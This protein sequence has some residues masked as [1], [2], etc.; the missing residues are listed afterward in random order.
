MSIGF[1]FN[2]LQSLY[3]AQL[4]Q[5]AARTSASTTSRAQE[6]SVLTPWDVRTPQRDAEQKLADALARPIT[7]NTN[8]P[9]FDR[10]GVPEDHKKLFG[11]YK[12]LST[13]SAIANEA[14][15]DKTSELRL[16]G[17]NRRFHDGL[18]TILSYVGKTEFDGLSLVAGEKAARVESAV[19]IARPSSAYTGAMAV[20]GAFDSAVAGLTGSETFT[21]HIVKSNVATDVTVDL[22]TISG[23]LTLDAIADAANTALE[24]AGMLT[25]FER[26]ATEKDEDGIARAFGLA[27]EGVGTEKVTLVPGAADPA[28]YL[29]GQSGTGDTAQGRFIKLTDLGA[30]APSVKTTQEFGDGEG[31]ITPA[32]SVTDAQGNVYVVGSTTGDLDGQAVK[33]ESDIFLRKYDSTGKLL[34]SKLL[35]AAESAEGFALASTGDGVVVAGKMAGEL[36]AASV[37]GKGDSVVVKFG[38]DGTEKFARQIA[39]LAEDGEAAITVGGD[40]A[41]YVAGYTKGKLAGVAAHGGGSDG[42]VTKLSATGGLVYNRQIGGAGEE[43]AQS[44]AVAGDGSLIVATIEDGNAVVRKYA[45]GDATS[46]AVWEKN[47]GEISG[48]KLSGIAVSGSDIYIAGSTGKLDFTAGGEASIAQAHSGGQAGFV[49]PLSDAGTSATADRVTYVGTG[50]Y[51]RITGIVVDGTDV[52]VSGVTKGALAG[53][54][55]PLTNSTHGFAAK[56]DASGATVWAKQFAGA[57]G[58]GSA[59]AIAIDTSGSSVLDVL[60]LPRGTLAETKSRLVTSNSSVR[61]GESFIVTVNG[62]ADRRIRIDA[63][64]TLRTLASKIN[65]VLVIEGKAEV[66]R[67][68]GAEVL[69]ITEKD[70]SSI[71]IKRGPDG[72][73]ALEGLGIQ[74][75]RVTADAPVSDDDS[76]TTTEAQPKVFGLNLDSTLSLLSQSK[77]AAAREALSDALS[78]IRN[79]YREITRDPA[80]DALAERQRKLSGPVPAYLREQ[81]A[82]YQ[83]A[84]ARLT[85][86]G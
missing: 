8:D 62:G 69:R 14:A 20:R 57:G 72:Y 6:T 22:S 9:S 21:L 60:G 50:T 27:I 3:T 76:E 59:A 85:G 48:G 37:G 45:S 16:P 28:I 23:P 11:L 52:Y 86:S 84:L 2:L 58:N 24:A 82:G 1:D 43:R 17:L 64:D 63:G 79:A 15:S 31:A 68:G 56:I 80:I 61:A 40:G 65:R 35:G 53:N 67:S 78:E 55:A 34:W 44:I 38:S 7:V 81:L 19:R 33:G 29:A 47:L 36:S 66:S 30:A 12:A 74:P 13:L 18:E 5:S 51:D 10:D 39:P 46:A 75:T 25:R 70:G 77:A 41:I 49:L 4:N 26:V 83:T 71:D 32:A 54:E 42:Y 73:D